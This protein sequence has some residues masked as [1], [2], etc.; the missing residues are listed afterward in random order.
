MCQLLVDIH[1]LMKLHVTCYSTSNQHILISIIKHL[2]VGLPERSGAL[3]KGICLLYD[4]PV[5]YCAFR[6]I[7]VYVAN[8]KHLMASNVQKH[9]I[10]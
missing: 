3:R 2:Y 6:A 4:N 7:K 10:V 9:R 8:A 1:R 5:L